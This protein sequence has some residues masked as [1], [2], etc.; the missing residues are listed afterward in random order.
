MASLAGKADPTLVSAAFRHGTSSMPYNLGPIYQQ[1]AANFQKFAEVT[2]DFMDNL[3]A[4]HINTEN[5]MNLLAESIQEGGGLVKH[6]DL[7]VLE[8]NQLHHLFQPNLLNLVIY[9]LFAVVP[10]VFVN[11]Q[12]LYQL[13]NLQND[14]P[15]PHTNFLL[16]RLDL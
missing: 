12:P 8:L 3:Y 10:F 6:L 14:F 2:K 5:N 13:L 11:L 15:Y 4:D 1:K 16:Q 7:L 9:L